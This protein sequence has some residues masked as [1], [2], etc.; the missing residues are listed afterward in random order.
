MFKL[1]VQLQPLV[2]AVVLCT[3]STTLGLGPW[4]RLVTVRFECC[5]LLV[6][7]LGAS[8][9]SC[10]QYVPV[11]IRVNAAGECVSFIRMLLASVSLNA[12]MLG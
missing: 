1:T 4:A 12:V 6:S 11:T 3:I 9:L 7:V 10:I 2:T 8:L 5:S